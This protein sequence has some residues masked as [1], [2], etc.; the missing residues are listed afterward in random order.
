MADFKIDSHKLMYHPER[1]A[2]WL[3]GEKIGPLY[4]E[5]SP[6][7]GCNHRC[8]FC[9]FNYLNYKATKISLEPMINCLDSMAECGVKAVMFAGEGEP[10]LHPRISDFIMYAC[11][12]GIDVSV[13]TNGVL[14][15]KKMSELTLPHMSWIKVSIDAATPETYAKVHG[16]SKRDFHKVLLNLEDA[17]DYRDKYE[18]DCTIGAQAILL[19]DNYDEIIHLADIIS[20]DYLVVK[21]FTGHPMRKGYNEVDYDS[22][23]G[24]VIHKLNAHPKINFRAHSFHRL[25]VKR[26]YTECYALDFWAFL[27]AAGEVYSCSN[28][29]GRPDVYSYGNINEKSF[30][31]IWDNR[32]VNVNIHDCRAICRMDKCNEYLWELKHPGPHVNFI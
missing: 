26:R 12:K 28:F 17:I 5:I 16:T 4:V 25:E 21:P 13:T 8:E 3:K 15:D 32:N 11:Q 19:P 1:V 18:L 27:T 23:P 22:M 14:F 24:D 7:A 29:L 10:L 2:E 31:E 6:F 9:A 20:A 30:K